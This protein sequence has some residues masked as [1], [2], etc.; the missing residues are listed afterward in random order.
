MVFPEA[1]AICYLNLF[2]EGRPIKF[3]ALSD[4]FLIKFTE[5]LFAAVFSAALLGEN[6]FQVTYLGSFILIFL[7]IALNTITATLP[8]RKK[9]DPH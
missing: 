6:I 3:Q 9:E 8:H 1:Y 4:L 5:T 2:L 7:G